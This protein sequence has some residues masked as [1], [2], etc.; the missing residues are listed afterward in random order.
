MAAWWAILRSSP[1]VI[2]HL[3]SIIRLQ[4][5]LAWGEVAD[6]ERYITLGVYTFHASIHEKE[7]EMS[8]SE[9]TFKER[10]SAIQTK[11]TQSTNLIHKFN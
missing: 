4:V 9:S 6:S 7:G 11:S 8:H 2:S 5:K 1:G 3:I 10:D